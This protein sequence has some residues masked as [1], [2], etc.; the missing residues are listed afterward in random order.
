MTDSL[1]RVP[2]SLRRGP[3]VVGVFGVLALVAA[4]VTVFAF[5]GGTT[6]LVWAIA[7]GVLVAGAVVGTYVAGRWVGQPHSHALAGSSVV[8]GVLVLAGVVAELLH[9]AGR[10][11]NV[12]IG[13]GLGGAVLV[14]LFVLVLVALLDRATAAA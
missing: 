2:E 11:S 14:T 9:S 8:F 6:Q 3:V 4:V 1:S 5:G 10:L 7:G 12:E 13:V